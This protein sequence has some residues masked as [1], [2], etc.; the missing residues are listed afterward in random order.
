[1][2]MHIVNQA[3]IYNLYPNHDN[4]LL[5]LN[6][7]CIHA[8]LASHPL[9]TEGVHFSSSVRSECMDIRSIYDTNL[10]DSVYTLSL[11]LSDSTVSTV[12][13]SDD[14]ANLTVYTTDFHGKLLG[15][16]A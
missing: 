2:V 13:I 4:L 8:D 9:L 14:R 16:D 10:N 12:I 11:T 1:M 6:F 7:V 5:V 15:L 3:I